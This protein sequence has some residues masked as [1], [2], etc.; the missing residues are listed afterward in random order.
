MPINLPLSLAAFCVGVIASFA[1]PMQG[2]AWLWGLLLI[3]SGASI[4]ITRKYR[5]RYVQAALTIF[6]F[7]FGLIYAIF[8][9]DMALKNHYPAHINP[10]TQSLTVTV[11]GLPETDWDTGR[12]RFI[13]KA[14][15]TQGKTYRIQFQDYHGTDWQVGDTWQFNAKIRAAIGTRNPV[16]FDRE[17]WALANQIDGIASVSKNRTKQPEKHSTLSF[18]Q[19][20][21]KTIMH[22]QAAA[23]DYP[24][25]A[26]LMTALAVG[27]KSGL[28]YETWAAL[29]PLGLHH[30]ISISGLH[31]GIV[32]IF[33]AW[34][35]KQIM[36]L[37]PFIPSRP[38]VWT[39]IIGAI[40]ALF[41]TGL[42]GFNIPTLRSLIML[43]VFAVTWITRGTIGTWRTWWIAMAAVLLYQPTAT[44][45]IGFWFSFGLV[46][47]LIWA[48]AFRLP[49][50][51]TL[52]IYRYFYL[53]KQT[54]IAQWAVTLMSGI[55]TIYAFGLLPIF[56]PLANAIAIPLFT[57]LLVPIALLSSLL[58]FDFL[59]YFAAYLGECTV[60]A[61][62]YWGNQLPELSFA[63]A[64]VSLLILALSG[65]LFLLLP[66]GL[67]I[68]PLACCAI[69]VFALYRPAPPS[70]SLKITVWD[71]GQGLS[72]LLQTPTRTVLFDTGTP[73]AEL[74]LLPN[75]RAANVRHIDRLIVSHHD[76]DHDGGL[77]AV[78][79][80]ISIGQLDAGQPEFYADATHCSAGKK[81][82]YDDVLFEYLTPTP[83]AEKD[84]DRSCVLRV[85]SGKHA[86]LITGDLGQHGEMQLVEKYGKNLSSDVF[87]LGHH[88]STSSNS[89]L[90]LNTLSPKIAIASSGFANAF[91]HPTPTVQRR[92]ADRDIQLWRT[93]LQG[94]IHVS[95]DKQG[96]QAAPLVKQSFWWQKKPFYSG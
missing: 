69:A 36:S 20:R 11:M 35:A 34:I 32:G 92:L 22:W 9:T 56:S 55:I 53:L 87:V 28:S 60:S 58:P 42:A 17:A 23:H 96:F 65:A 48:C 19:L 27:N 52:R 90:L 93:D 66:N 15:T 1:L 85:S 72:V 73:A 40:A 51:E 29:R 33:A 45:A 61:L 18:N 31:I 44:L 46:G 43:T 39:L 50:K 81:W 6:L 67:R 84:N 70:G 26:G 71:V 5:P 79:K 25:G 91:R 47:T 13:G 16:G 41:Y 21:Q 14:T 76:N 75:L 63:H 89:T 37:L 62:V 80:N 12:T 74:A 4:W 82:Q 59:K 7:I 8:R 86:L 24:N 88:G 95:L 30:L 49:E 57:C 94:A 68:K 64:P 77:A 2:M 10:P 38:R 83:Q 3:G 54:I 78:Q